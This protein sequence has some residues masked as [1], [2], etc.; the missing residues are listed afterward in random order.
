MPKASPPHRN[1]RRQQASRV[2]EATRARSAVWR[3]PH[4]YHSEVSDKAIGR[5]V[6]PE[7]VGD[8][9]DPFNDMPR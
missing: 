6:A 2:R 7:L 3:E 4:E 8:F 5:L 9:E 1:A